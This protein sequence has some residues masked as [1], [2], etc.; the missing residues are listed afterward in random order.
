MVVSDLPL[1]MAINSVVLLLAFKLVLAL[2]WARRNV[3]AEAFVVT[4]LVLNKNQINLY[5]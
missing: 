3:F 4:A 5:T 1:R 2:P